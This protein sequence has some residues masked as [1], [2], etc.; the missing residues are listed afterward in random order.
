MAA[1]FREGRSVAIRDNREIPVAEAEFTHWTQDGRVRHRLL[2]GIG[3]EK[4]ARE[5]MIE[6]PAD[7]KRY[8]VPNPMAKPAQASSLRGSGEVRR[9]TGRGSCASIR[10]MSRSAGINGAVG[11]RIFAAIEEPQRLRWEGERLIRCRRTRAHDSC[12]I[13]PPPR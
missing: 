10:L 6:G 13:A 5:V 3:E 9:S 12:D 1:A 2:N 7:R 11:R 8:P 4:D